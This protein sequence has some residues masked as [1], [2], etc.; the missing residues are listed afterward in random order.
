MSSYCDHGKYHNRHR[1]GCRK[2]ICAS[3]PP[4]PKGDKGDTGKQGIPGRDGKDGKDGKDGDKG[5]TGEQGIPGPPGPSLPSIGNVFF[6]GTDRGYQRVIGMNHES[7]SQPIQ[8]FSSGELHAFY[9]SVP[10]S[11]SLTTGDTM[12]IASLPCFYIKEDTPDLTNPINSDMIM[13]RI[14]IESIINTT[15]EPI[16]INDVRG[17][18]TL[19]ILPSDGTRQQNICI[20]DQNG[21]ET[22]YAIQIS[23]TPGLAGKSFDRDANIALWADFVATGMLFV[24]NM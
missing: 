17:P 2:T 9:F 15:N 7:Q 16:I 19:N 23:W 5:D 13:A 6:E 14:R 24:I 3:C 4:G 11:K 8:T 20:V 1:N 21:D 22:D 10:L 12:L 18:L